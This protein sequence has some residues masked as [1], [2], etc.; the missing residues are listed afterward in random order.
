MRM[1]QVIGVVCMIAGWG[2]MSPRFGEAAPP[3]SADRPPTRAERLAQWQAAIEVNVPAEQPLSG[4]LARDLR[5]R[6]RAIVREDIAAWETLRTRDD[7]ERLRDE[8]L[9]KLRRAIGEFPAPPQDLHARIT[10]TH[11]GEGYRVECLVFESRPGLWVTA[12]VYRPL[13]ARKSMPGIVICHSH[14]R[15]KTQDELQEMG[16]AWARTGCVVV[17]PDMLGHGERRQ[18]PFRTADDW[19]TPFRVERQD[20]QFRYNVGMQLHLIGDSLM[21]WFVWDLSRCVDWLLAQPGVDPGRIALLGAVAGGGDPAAVAAALDRRITVAVPFNFGGPQPESEYPLPT[22][23]ASS[24]NYVGGGSFESTRNLTGTGAGRFFPW[25]IV[26]AV[27][28]R[29]L[30]YAHEFSWDRERDPVWK[31]LEKIYA[32]YDKPQHLSSTNGWGKVTQSSSEASHCTNIGRPHRK[33]IHAS[34]EQWLNIPTPE[35][36]WNRRFESKQL[37]C[38]E[39]NE[40]AKGITLTPVHE[41]AK[42]IAAERGAAFRGRTLLREA[43][44]ECLALHLPQSAPPFTAVKSSGDEPRSV[45]GWLKTEREII[46]PVT[47]LLPDSAIAVEKPASK[48][49]SKAS[50][51]DVG[52][53]VVV[54][55]CQQGQA[56][57]LKQRA[58]E[59]AK[60][61]DGGVAVCLPDLRG[62]GATQ[63]D[64]GRGRRS[65]ST[66]LS[67]SELLL[68]GTQ[69]GGQLHDLLAVL[70]WLRERPEVKGNCVGIW[71]ESL[72]APNGAEVRIDT[73]HDAGPEVRIGDPG[74]GV[75]ALLAS[76]F[77][78]RVER[79]LGR[80]M[81][82][83]YATLLDGPFIH[84]PH[85]VV[86][87]G[88]LTLGDLADVAAVAGPRFL[89]IDRAIDATNRPLEDQRLASL[90]SRA[91]QAYETRKAALQLGGAAVDPAEWFLGTGASACDS[92]STKVETKP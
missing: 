18:H 5:E 11:D 91:R 65:S 50:A 62:C 43:W 4:L 73:P 90:W 85:D 1:S 44:R 32:W 40:A 81:I 72:V 45:R 29:P 2:V 88:V 71:G 77:D 76:V 55:V 25:V 34:F 26:G 38:V 47:L 54:V 24:F 84:L 27:A 68:G 12:N 33:A 51:D 70:L 3:A 23:A 75:L 89:R 61:L 86:V 6:R 69:L 64:T 66:S 8:R 57:L 59:I 14:H 36:E 16:A 19:P 79:V 67:S 17:V 22:D 30:V 28:P 87:P 49:S 82:G 63:A 56:G 20:Y 21:G 31:R 35:L 42:G 13:P 53:P 60:L 92:S 83:A 58:T 37:W 78:E 52:T 46:V 41:L 48:E 15:P 74:A 9:E 80:G 10:R 7:W 39:G